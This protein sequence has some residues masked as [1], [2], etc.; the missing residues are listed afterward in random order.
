MEHL[1]K[2]ILSFFLIT[3][4]IPDIQTK[5]KHS[6]AS[7]YG[8]N[9]RG[10]KTAS[11]KSFNPDKLIAAHKK[12]PFGTKVEV[13]NMDNNASIIV[14]IEDRGPYIKNRSLDLSK[15]A[16]DSIAN[17]KIGVINVK[18]RIL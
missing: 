10:K 13:I 14:T 15:A 2:Y 16:F 9:F 8:D 7:W 3:A 1:L 6:Q 18:Y 12:L 4:P 5:Y 11:G 17:L